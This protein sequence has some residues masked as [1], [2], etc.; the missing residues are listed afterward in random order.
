MAGLEVELNEM[1]RT[2]QTAWFIGIILTATS[3][4]ISAQTLLDV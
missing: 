3:V 2:D 1:L 4:S